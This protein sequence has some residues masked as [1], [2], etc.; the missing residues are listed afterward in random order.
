M[1]MNNDLQHSR[2]LATVARLGALAEDHHRFIDKRVLLLGEAPILATANGRMCLISSLRLLVRICRNITILLPSGFDDL[3]KE[4]QEVAEHI[5]YDQKITFQEVLCDLKVYDAI[6][7]VGATVNPALPWTVIN[8]N[9]WLV[10]VSSGS[11]SLASDCYQSNP[12]AALAAACLGVTEVFKRLIK[13]SENRGNYF[14]G[15]NFSL[16]SYECCTTDIGPTLPQRLPLD[17]LIVGVGAI[18]N[19]VVYL[20]SVLPIVGRIAIVDGQT[21]QFENL[22]TCLLIGPGDLNKEKAIFA[23]KL[24]AKDGVVVEGFAEDFLTFRKRLGS[25]TPHPRIVLNGLD[26]IEARHEVQAL[27]PDLIIDGAIGD[28]ACQ[29]SCHPWGKD[30]ACLKCLFQNPAGEFANRIASRLTGLSIE[31]S[32]QALTTVTEQDILLASPEKQNWL[33]GRLGQQICSV[34]QE[35][36]IQ[37]I[38][39]ERQ[40][41]R[42]EPSVP[43]VAC[44]SASMMVAELVKYTMGLPTKLEP[45]FQMDVL[46]GP[47]FGQELLQ[48]RRRD[49]MCVTRSDN[50]ETVRQHH[51]E[52]VR[53]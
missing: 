6:L 45:R 20:L 23:E 16:Y 24:L 1:K 19:G 53:N 22:G 35:A 34:I 28:F 21:Y 38:S 49:C 5:N 27:W 48:C 52:P 7:C 44:L 3:S 43:F 30:V 10:R 39:D 31:R 4:C 50:I 46:Q 11:K 12:I 51:L 15:L 32:Q 14:D 40:R 37:S 13:L 26:N 47:E 25:Q 8:S 41:D 36:V 9:G 18:G 33:K 42:F 2:P 17:L 29:V